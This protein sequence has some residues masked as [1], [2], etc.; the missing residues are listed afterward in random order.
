MFGMHNQETF[1]E[2]VKKLFGDSDPNYLIDILPKTSESRTWFQV[3][4]YFL[5]SLWEEIW[6]KH[7][8]IILKI[9]SYYEFELYLYQSNYFTSTD[10]GDR[11]LDIFDKKIEHDTI[12]ETVEIM[13]YA[14]CNMNILLYIYLPE[15]KSLIS[16]SDSDFIYLNL[17]GF[18]EET[19]VQL[20]KEIALSEGMFL[21]KV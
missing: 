17:Y 7:I 2:L 6:K 9:F 12:A 3:E 11:V 14:L 20:L 16:K 4:E 13:R 8:Y 15:I 18:Q 1:L 5:S 21:R 10:L 19:D